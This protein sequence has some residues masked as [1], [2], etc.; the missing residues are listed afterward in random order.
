MEGGTDHSVGGGS[1]GAVETRE[2]NI[3]EYCYCLQLLS[4]TKLDFDLD[5][6]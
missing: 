3:A 2:E 5:I 6:G 1:Y 4:D